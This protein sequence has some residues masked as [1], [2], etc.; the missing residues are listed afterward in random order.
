MSQ[1]VGNV[2]SY[3]LETPISELYLTLFSQTAL[4]YAK[5]WHHADASGRILGKFAVRI[6]NVLMGKHKPMYD[7]AGEFF[8]TLV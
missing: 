1:A 6:A 2:S 5:S 3:Q 7:P 4:A 8:C